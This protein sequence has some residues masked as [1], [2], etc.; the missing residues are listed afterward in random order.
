MNVSEKYKAWFNQRSASEDL[1]INAKYHSQEAFKNIDCLSCGQCCR[2]TV[3]TFDE[4]D[5]TKTAKWMNI[6]KKEFIKKYLIIDVDKSYTTISVPCPFL[7]LQDN[8]CAIYE[9]RPK[10]CVS[11]PHTD[12]PFFLRRKK[13]HLANSK[14]CLITQYVLDRMTEM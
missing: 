8:K 7:N 2:T 11:F 5:I 9:V 13:A 14:F 12:R 4:D 6:S 1:D 3:T 10:S